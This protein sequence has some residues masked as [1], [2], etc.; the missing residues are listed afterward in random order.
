MAT[1]EDRGE[2]KG[3][4]KVLERYGRRARWLHAGTYLTVLGLGVHRRLAAPGPRGSALAAQQLAGMPDTRLHVWLGWAFVG[5]VA[6]GVWPAAQR[7]LVRRR[8]AAVQ[9]GRP[10]VVQGLAEGAPHRALPVAQR[11]VPTR[12]KGSP[13]SPSSSVCSR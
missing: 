10:R 9:E 8:L 3:D 5:L 6:L 4:E 13:T 2:E 12:V 1:D 11:P 7:P